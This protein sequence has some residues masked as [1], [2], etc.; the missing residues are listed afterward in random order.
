MTILDQVQNP[1]RQM[2]SNM[3]DQTTPI[4]VGREER[5]L[6]AFLG[7]ALL[8]AGAMKGWRGALATLIPGSY[9]LFRGST[10]HCFVYDRIGI[11][12]AVAT[13]PANVAVPHKQG[14]R[15]EKTM[16]INRT[17]QELYTFW[18]HFE[19]L[20]RFMNHLESVTV[21][22]PTR[23]HWVA[24]APA[25]MKVEWDAEIITDTPNEVI[26]WRSLPDAQV[27]NAGSVRFMRAPG[28]VG[29]EM[30]VQLEYTPPAGP[31][32]AAF[33]RLFGEEPNQQVE[34]DLNRFKQLMETGQVPSA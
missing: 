23:S 6:S 24:K 4:N 19:N 20:P 27:P 3:Q 34:E 17:P 25:G 26:G 31:I 11:N 1:Q 5:I 33:A 18:H 2:T 12:T 28:G 32:G 15:V 10:G 16:T 9:L 7:G 8:I 30:R 29:T 13:N 22:S 21:L 14:I